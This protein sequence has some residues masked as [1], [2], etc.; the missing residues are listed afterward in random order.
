MHRFKIALAVALGLTLAAGAQA[1][2][3]GDARNPGTASLAPPKDAP[4]SRP[5]RRGPMR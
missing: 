2:P 3:P 4:R 5:G 1:Q